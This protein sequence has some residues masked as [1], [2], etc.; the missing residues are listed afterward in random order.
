M[1]GTHDITVPHLGASEVWSRT[2]SSQQPYKGRVSSLWLSNEKTKH[3]EA[4]QA[5]HSQTASH[6]WAPN[7]NPRGLAPESVTVWW[8]LY[9]FRAYV[10]ILGTNE[11][12]VNVLVVRYH[13]CYPTIMAVLAFTWAHRSSY[14]RLN[15]CPR[16][17]AQR[18]FVQQIL[19]ARSKILSYE[20]IN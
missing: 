15:F 17:S 16:V 3:R 8:S 7:S 6:Q 14:C 4:E 11:R 9:S 2:L 1:S 5:A 18:T 10:K 20:P 12:A 13:I 19:N